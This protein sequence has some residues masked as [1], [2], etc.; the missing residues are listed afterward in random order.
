MSHSGG[1]PPADLEP[2]CGGVRVI[3]SSGRRLPGAARNAGV[4][5]STAPYIAFLAADCRALPGWAD[6]RLRRHRAGAAA[7]A[8]AM[9][10][11]QSEPA[12]VA[13]HLLQHSSRMRHLQMPAELRFGLSYSRAL[14]ER[15]GPF[16]EQVPGEEDVALNG[17]L[18]AAG[19]EVAWAP[20]VETAHAYPPT[21]RALIADQWARGR[22]RAYVRRR[23]R[24]LL[25]GRALLD[26][27]AGIARAARPG[28][29]IR[30]AELVRAV[31]LLAAGALV[32]AV[33]T[34]LGP[35]G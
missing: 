4:A 31:P 21:P 33:G 20:E 17:R 11:L 14:L 35:R 26:G 32:T 8:S 29:P 6:G 13:S 23:P 34:A 10:T 15:Y 7:V 28:S 2:L 25:V 19:V 9:T 24:P 27:P 1:E 12:A 16:P 30:A 5:A 22:R 3:S 18:I